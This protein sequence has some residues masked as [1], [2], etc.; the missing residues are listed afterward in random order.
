MLYLGFPWALLTPP[1]ALVAVLW[2]LA[3]PGG[4]SYRVTGLRNAD[5]RSPSLLQIKP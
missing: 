5:S 1:L 2:S 4:L 3:D